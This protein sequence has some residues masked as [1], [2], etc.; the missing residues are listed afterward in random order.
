MTYPGPLRFRGVRVVAKAVWV[1]LAV[2]AV[3]LTTS[4]LGASFHIENTAVAVAA[5]RHGHTLVARACFLLLGLA[6]VAWF[7]FE[8][9]RW[10]VVVL[11]LVALVLLVAG[12]TGLAFLFIPLPYLTVPAAA[13]GA[14]WLPRSRHVAGGDAVSPG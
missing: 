13:V 3:W 14:L 6:A 8:A 4:G 5:E 12:S 10:S 7:A 1:A 2:V 9:P 11:S